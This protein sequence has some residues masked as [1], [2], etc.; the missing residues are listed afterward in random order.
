MIDAVVIPTGYITT[1]GY[2]TR[3]LV[4]S[5]ST[6]T[7][8]NPRAHRFSRNFR[9]VRRDRRDVGERYRRYP[10]DIAGG[11]GPDR[12]CLRHVSPGGTIVEIMYLVHYCLR[13]FER[14]LDQTYLVLRQAVETRKSCLCSLF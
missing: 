8:N 12:G 5:T 11:V 2:T 13:E 1:A 9:H 7:H 3:L 14:T 6:Q 4:D 10:P